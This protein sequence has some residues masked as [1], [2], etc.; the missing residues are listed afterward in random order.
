MYK[1]LKTLSKSFNV[2]KEHLVTI[3]N[4]LTIELKLIKIGENSIL[5]T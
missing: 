1:T 5:S 4:S 3:S 2:P